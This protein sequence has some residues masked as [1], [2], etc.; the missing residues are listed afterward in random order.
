MRVKL[1][2]VGLLM[3][4]Q[5][6]YMFIQGSYIYIYIYIYIEREREIEREWERS[7]YGIVAK[8]MDF[9]ILVWT[10]LTLLHSLLDLFPWKRHEPRVFN[11]DPGDQG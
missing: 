9:D 1:I 5:V 7:S 6:L 8:V 10:P 2:C 11:N 4:F 3:F